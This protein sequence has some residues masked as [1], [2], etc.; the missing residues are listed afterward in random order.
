MSSTQ[1]ETPYLLKG[2]F[3][4]HEGYSMSPSTCVKRQRDGST[5][6]TRYYVS[7]K[8]IKQ[9]YAN[10]DLKSINAQQ[11]EGLV[12]SIVV[13]VLTEQ[14][15]EYK[16]ALSQKTETQLNAIYKTMIVGVTAS[17]NRINVELSKATIDEVRMTLAKCLSGNTNQEH[18]TSLPVLIYE[19]KITE[20]NN[21]IIAAVDVEIK[22]VDGKRFILSP[23]KTDL[24][25]HNNSKQNPQILTALRD[26]HQLR[27]ALNAS[28][29]KN[30]KETA[31]ALKVNYLMM[32]RKLPLTTLSPYIQKLALAEELPERISLKHLLKVSQELSWK[33]QSL[34]LKL[35][36]LL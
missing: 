20:N 36:E 24:Y 6:H 7:Q 29:H 9:G 13:S 14:R 12:I 34:S 28:S 16:Q 32:L 5:K 3:R 22:K 35:S 18:Q 4:H 2:K 21:S 8:A 33:D 30:V 10:C 26:A 23:D 11:I 17:S 27:I 31:K 1:S 19:P 15:E 25:K